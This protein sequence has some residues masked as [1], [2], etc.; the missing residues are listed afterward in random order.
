MQIDA[1][2]IQNMMLRKTLKEQRSPKNHF[3]SSLLKNQ[4][5]KF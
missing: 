4:L 3:H 2:G 5:N 1:K